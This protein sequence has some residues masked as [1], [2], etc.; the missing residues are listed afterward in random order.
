M[1]DEIVITETENISRADGVH[2]RQYGQVP[3]AGE[4]QY[5]V[6]IVATKGRIIAR[7]GSDGGY[8]QDQISVPWTKV[9]QHASMAA[10]LAEIDR[11]KA[12]NRFET[13]ELV[14][15][16]GPGRVSGYQLDWGTRQDYFAHVGG[17]EMIP[18]S[19]DEAKSILKW[20]KKGPCLKWFEKGAD[21]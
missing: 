17:G 2:G 9:L 7:F 10:L 8:I 11:P 19:P 12:A 13:G 3:S 18:I 21:K 16:V 5:G 20:F 15:G 1:S 6:E 14:C 4:V